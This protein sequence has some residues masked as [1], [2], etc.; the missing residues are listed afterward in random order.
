M[1]LDLLLA[2]FVLAGVFHG[3][4]GGTAF[5][6][7]GI[8]ALVG[9]AAFGV[10][11]AR[12]AL[13]FLGVTGGEGAGDGLRVFCACFGAVW[14]AIHAVGIGVRTGRNRLA[15]GASDQMLGAAAGTAHAVLACV[16]LTGVALMLAPS[17]RP[18]LVERPLGQVADRS[19]DS[20]AA[21]LASSAQSASIRVD[22][23]DDA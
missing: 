23:S 14:L 1:A 15:G 13:I 2:A 6:V 10:F 8:L 18:T 16:A 21:H 17:L 3:S 9:G 7:T 4:R 11:L 5:H 20:I 19:V 22:A 12:L